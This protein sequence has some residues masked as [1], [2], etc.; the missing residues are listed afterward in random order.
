MNVGPFFTTTLVFTVSDFK[1]CCR[2]SNT[3]RI[4]NMQISIF[5]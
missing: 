2:I 5:T 3:R 1:C 4:L